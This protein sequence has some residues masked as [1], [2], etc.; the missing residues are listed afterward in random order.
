MQRSH[1]DS[2]ARDDAGRGRPRA[3]PATVA[4][5][6]RELQRSAGNRAVARAVADERA[7][8]GRVLARDGGPA[9]TAAATAAS[10]PPVRRKEVNR[11][12]T[13][14]ISHAP[15]AFAAWE[16][17]YEW[18]SKW[19]LKLDMRAEVGELDVKVR[20]YSTASAAVKR[21]WARAIRAKWSGKFAFCVK[22][23]EPIALAG[24][25]VDEFAEMYP[26]WI[27]I[28]W[29]ND[30][31][32]A[33]YTVT[34]NAAGAAEGGRAGEGGTTSMTGWG[35]ADTKDVTHEFGHILGCPE[36]YFTTNGVD[37]SRGGRRQGF[38]DPGGGVMNNPAGPALARNLDVVR[39]EAA[40]LRGV[41]RSKTKVV[42]WR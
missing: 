26:I 13:E 38:R 7:G 31:A 15:A 27:T 23:D 11:R 41:S 40:A 8:R 29:V 6:V 28:E 33:H 34:A 4:E 16:G 32:K 2:L 39:G 14:R 5:R 20:L 10:S 37:Y 18:R 22:R 24:G 12:I 9:T 25:G 30:P 21:A 17:T 36:E 1:A 19:R 35:T 42:P 3:T